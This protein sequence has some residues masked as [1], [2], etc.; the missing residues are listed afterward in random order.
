MTVSVVELF[1]LFWS[2]SLVR[3]ALPCVMHPFPDW[4]LDSHETY[5]LTQSLSLSRF[6]SVTTESK[7]QKGEVVGS[8]DPDTIDPGWSEVFRERHSG[9]VPPGRRGRDCGRFLS[10]PRLWGSDGV[11]VL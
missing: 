10:R 6:P 3:G 2:S 7:S 11:G 1:S 5:P 4:R 8:S 9:G